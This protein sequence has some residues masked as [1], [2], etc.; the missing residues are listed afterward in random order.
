MATTTPNQAL[1]TV[2]VGRTTY[3]VELTYV[4]G[5]T[6]MIS[7]GQPSLLTAG[8]LESILSVRKTATSLDDIIITT[9][10]SLLGEKTLGTPS[11][12]LSTS[13]TTLTSNVFRSRSRSSSRSNSSLSSPTPSSSR[14]TFST[15]TS[16]KSSSLSR[17]L[18]SSPPTSVSGK[19]VS[20]TITISTAAVG[21]QT[22]NPQLPQIPKTQP[23]ILIGVPVAVVIGTILGLAL[24][25]LLKK[26]WKKRGRT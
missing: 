22:L 18:S 8:Q 24:F 4:S 15:S 11:R 10:P 20:S 16:P 7:N 9:W 13:A 6:L 1:Q 14:S 23:S 25:F 2:T 12:V 3:T 19:S 26:K 17:P 5:P 21:P